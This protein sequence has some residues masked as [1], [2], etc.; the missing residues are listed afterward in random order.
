MKMKNFF[1]SI[2]LS[3]FI[4]ASVI[5]SGCSDYLNIV[6][7]NIT[8]VDKMFENKSKILQAL[9]TCYSFIPD[10]FNDHYR[11]NLTLGNEYMFP[12]IYAHRTDVFVSNRIMMGDQ[13]AD[14]PYLN[15]WDGGNL[16]AGIRYCNIF[17]NNIREVPDLEPGDYNDYIA[18]IKFLKAYFHFLLINSYGPIII[19]DT[20]MDLNASVV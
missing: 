14:A 18:Q 13:N 6:P 11:T 9:A 20:E 3:L 1:K 8:T 17:L 12:T 7:D 4:M 19:S 2:T 5:F 10:K 16:Y 15:Y